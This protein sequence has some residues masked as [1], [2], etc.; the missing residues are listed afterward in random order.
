MVSFQVVR[1]CAKFFVLANKPLL[2]YGVGVF[3][4][5]G[6]SEKCRITF[7]WSEISG[8]VGKISIVPPISSI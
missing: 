3:L 6:S 5:L 1:S 2:K 8:N 7:A 4:G